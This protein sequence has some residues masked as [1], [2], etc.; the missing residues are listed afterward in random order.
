ML[1]IKPVPAFQDN[2]VWPANG[3]TAIVDP[4]DA[5]PVLDAVNE[6]RLTPVAILTT[7][8]HGTSFTCHSGILG[9][10]SSISIS[11]KVGS[12]PRQA[13]HFIWCKSAISRPLSINNTKIYLYYEDYTYNFGSHAKQ[14]KEPP[15]QWP[16]YTSFSPLR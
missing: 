7:H 13:T 6:N 12:P 5:A 14:A 10:N 9:C 2:Y 11:V 8:H 15:K 16:F 4:G 1:E 3:A